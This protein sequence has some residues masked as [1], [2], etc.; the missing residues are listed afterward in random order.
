MN[1]LK[2]IVDAF[3]AL[4]WS[5]QF[6]VI[7]ILFISAMLLIALVFAVFV[8]A[9]RIRTE[10]AR[11]RWV[12]LETEWE[13]RLLDVLA[14]SDGA[15]DFVVP[16][17]AENRFVS[18][19]S[20]YAR[21]LRGGER[22]TLR[23]LAQPYLSHMERELRSKAP[24]RRAHAVLTLSDLGGSEHEAALVGRLDDESSLVAMVAARSLANSDR[25]DY[26]AAILARI[27]RF[28]RWNPRHLAAMFA[29]MGP[30]A[31]PSL[32]DTLADPRASERG[33][34]VAA[35]AL[36]LLRDFGAVHAAHDIADGW[37]TPNVLIAA[38]RLLTAVGSDADAPVARRCVTSAHAP[39]RGA[40]IL[41]IGALG[42]ASD[43]PLIE[44]TLQ[45][46]VPWVALNA[47]AALREIG[48]EERLKAI[49][50]TDTAG[51]HAARELMERTVS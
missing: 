32:R 28:E 48:A 16:A 2:R 50:S 43:I 49:A 17:G 23:A 14:E 20:R 6:L 35:E 45:D 39:V 13:S 44:I 21:Q 36:L 40:A 26:A 51:G 30:K 7:L 24:E 15:Q 41:A 4:Y 34:V 19:L 8:V 33:R 38:L 1:R 22:V 47:A 5:D 37:A 27:D 25:A 12:D 29:A 18:F 31:A 3:D 9:V 10:R 11:A 46:E 42:D